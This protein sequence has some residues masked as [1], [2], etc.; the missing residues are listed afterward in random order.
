[1]WN[2]NTKNSNLESYNLAHF[3]LKAIQ[4]I[5]LTKNGLVNWDPKDACHKLTFPSPSHTPNLFP[6]WENL[7]LV[8]L[9]KTPEGLGVL[10]TCWWVHSQTWTDPSCPPVM[11]S[12]SVGC[13]YMRLMFSIFLFNTYN[14]LKIMLF[15]F[16]LN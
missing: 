7:H 11:Y 6:W 13:G 12:G 2:F 3:E 16:L 4:R 9:A 1:M 14:S 8:T 15:T 10:T 5:K